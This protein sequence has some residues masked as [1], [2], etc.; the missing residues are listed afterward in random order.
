MG[1]GGGHPTKRNRTH[2][3]VRFLSPSSTHPSTHTRTT[4][5]NTTKKQV[6][7]L[8]TLDA[9]GVVQAAIMAL[10]SVLSTDFRGTEVRAVRLAA[11]SVCLGFGWAARDG[12][13]FVPAVR[14]LF[15]LEAR[16]MLGRECFFLNWRREP[17][18][19]SFP[20]PRHERNATRGTPPINR[21]INTTI[22]PH[23]SPPPLYTLRWR[24]GW[25]RAW[26]ATSAHLRW[27][28]STPT[29]RPSRS[30]TRNFFKKREG[31]WEREEWGL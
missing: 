31:C 14:C 20:R 9:D 28:R 11:A 27:R 15:E 29:S 10:Q 3:H 13:R 2:A 26:R 6:A 21:H 8:P 23:D 24:S 16:A 18:G 5:N 30:G 7:D 17:L 12:V 19:Q 1:E 25:Y 22:R 4:T